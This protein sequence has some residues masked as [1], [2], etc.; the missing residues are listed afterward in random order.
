VHSIVDLGHNLGFSVVGEGVETRT[1]LD[2]LAATGCDV[3]Q[4]YLFTR[5]MA[6]DLLIAWLNDYAMAGASSRF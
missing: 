6:S 1:V 2:E 5:P 4:G 3:A